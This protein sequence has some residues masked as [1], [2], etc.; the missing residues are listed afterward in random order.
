MRYNVTTVIGE[1]RFPRSYTINS[2]KPITSWKGVTVIFSRN[3]NDHGLVK[4]RRF[5]GLAERFEGVSPHCWGLWPVMAV[6][7]VVL[8]VLLVAETTNGHWMWAIALVWLTS[9][10]IFTIMAWYEGRPRLRDVFSSFLQSWAFLY[11]DLLVLP[12][13]FA[14]AAHAYGTTDAAQ[15]TIPLW[16]EILGGAIGL[17]FGL[18]FHFLMEV[19]AYTENDYEDRLNSPSKIWH[20]LAVYPVLS[21]A[22]IVTAGSLLQ[23]DHGWPWHWN[24]SG[25]VLG[26][27]FC[28]AVWAVLG[29]VCDGMRAA[30]L[31]PWGHIAWDVQNAQP[32]FE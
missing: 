30:R 23:V 20:D 15:L 25:H 31:I 27:L 4:Q 24:F 9:P 5:A 6:A 12:A 17:A 13:A 21:G 28:I 2:R 14:L 7:A 19:P 29:M 3:K 8:F 26:I 10:V 1:A 18:G 11:G 32:V 16:W 22:L